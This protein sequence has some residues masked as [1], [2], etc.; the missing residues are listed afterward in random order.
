MYGTTVLAVRKDKQVRATQTLG[1]V[2]CSAR[3]R[4]DDLRQLTEQ[5]LRVSS[6][7]SDLHKDCPLIAGFP[8]SA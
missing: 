4:L 8:M 5:R 7:A 3:P 1:F 6:D 2:S